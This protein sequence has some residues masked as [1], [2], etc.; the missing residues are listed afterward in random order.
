M[1]WRSCS[2]YYGPEVV[3]FAV[4]DWW[5]SRESLKS[6][7]WDFFLCEMISKSSLDAQ[8]THVPLCDP[9]LSKGDVSG[10]GISVRSKML[11]CKV[12]V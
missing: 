11:N 9:T 4:N 7:F 5:G 2:N 1:I 10:S 3:R 6:K 8:G 12:F